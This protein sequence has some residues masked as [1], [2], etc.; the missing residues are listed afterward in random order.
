[1]GGSNPHDALDPIDSGQIIT[2]HV[3]DGMALAKQ[4]ELPAKVAAF[5][6]EHHGTRL[7][8]YFY[9]KAAEAEPDIDPD[10][11]RYPGPKPQSRETAI[12][13]LA[14]SAEA[15]VRSSSD[16]S[17]ER[18]DAIVDE[19]FNERLVEGQL[20]ESDL[21]LRNLRDLSNSFK[22]TLRAMY[23]PRIEYPAP[24]ETELFLRRLPFRGRVTSNK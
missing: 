19:V 12:A 3:R 18:I 24:S 6:P 1:M 14:D 20:D 15:T 22:A 13:M 23:H 9:R 2:D 11:F 7:A 16:K 21:T 8:L 10:M 17:P 4:Y 5:V